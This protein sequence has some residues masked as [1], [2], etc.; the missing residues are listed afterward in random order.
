MKLKKTIRMPLRRVP[1]R[2]RPPAAAPLRARVATADEAYEDGGYETEEE[3]NMKLSHAF[4]VVLILHIIAVGSI[5][6]FNSIKAR[7]AADGKALAKAAAAEA[8]A[9]AESASGTD[10]ASPGEA[11]PAEAAPATTYTVVSGDTLKRIAIAHQTTVEALQKANGLTSY[12]VIRVGQILKLPSAETVPAE[13]AAKESK[14]ETIPLKASSTPAPVTTVSREPAKE[15]SVAKTA[16]TAKETAKTSTA[17]AKSS[18]SPAAK[19]ADAAGEK[20]Y[21]VAKGENPY[22]IA[23]KL[24]VSYSALISLN[25]IKDPTKI[26]IG[27]KLKIPP[28]KKD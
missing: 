25:G 1:Q 28:T 13:V 9:S 19:T 20:V 6:A 15:T 5:F 14:E 23:K 12:S 17:S 7:Q 18:A 4:L 27:Q 24:H 26:Q 21:V 16:S 22:S 3:P 11:A 2:S 8:A 10:N